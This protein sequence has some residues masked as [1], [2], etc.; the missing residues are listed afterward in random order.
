MKVDN[1]V[2]GAVAHRPI[3]HPA[4]GAITRALSVDELVST[5]LR[6]SVNLECNGNEICSSHPRQT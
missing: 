2:A 5:V 3:N 6:E 1:D 4:A